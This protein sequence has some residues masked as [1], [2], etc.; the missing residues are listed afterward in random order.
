MSLPNAIPA[1]TLVLMRPVPSAPELLMIER[2]ADMAFAPGAMVFPGGRIDPDDHVLG[3]DALGAAKVAAIRETIE[4]TGIAVA[5][6]PPPGEALEAAIRAHLHGGVPFSALLSRHRLALDPDALV[7]FARWRPTFRET[8]RFD[9]L[10]FLA[11]A[12]ADSSLPTADAA[13]SV[14]ALWITAGEVLARAEEGEAHIIFPTRRNLERLARFA[15]FEEAAADAR[16]HRVEAIVP[17]IEERGGTSWL[18]IPEGRG[19]PITA[20]PLETARRR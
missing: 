12:P 18:C 7:P 13:E 10:F 3:G 1:A 14:H 6:K 17:W 5:L 2:G 9:T 20:E 4:E 8:R 15:S 19:Y 11:R 16:A